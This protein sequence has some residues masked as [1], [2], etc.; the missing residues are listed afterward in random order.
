MRTQAL[1]SYLSRVGLE[2]I[3]NI[4]DTNLTS[5]YK[6]ICSKEY[7]TTQSFWRSYQ[8]SGFGQ[9]TVVSEGTAIPEDDIFTGY[10]KDYT[11][12]KRGLGFSIST[13]ASESDQY[14][15][16]RDIATKLRNA[17]RRTKE[18]V[19]ANVINNATS[20]SYTGPDGKALAA[21][22]HPLDSGTASNLMTAG[23]FGATNLEDMIEA[24][25]SQEGHRGDPDPCMGPFYLYIHPGLG[26]LAR[27]VTESPML[28]GTANNDLNIY[29]RGR[30]VKVVDSPYFTDEN[31]WAIRA[32]NNDDHGLLM[33]N[34][35]GIRVKSE[36]DIDLDAMKY[37]A[38]EMYLASFNNWRGYRHNAGA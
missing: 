19:A 17:F 23:A 38:T 31:F 37:R 13:E 6:D 18:Q 14:G 28:Q 36:E 34:R 2:N 21:T 12:V 1:S 30:I 15:A 25:V 10:P 33:V 32:A 11:P 3:V 16:L 9:A 20:S 5:Y 24:M 22:D 26:A 4:D 29:N 8:T 27:R 35:R 7:S